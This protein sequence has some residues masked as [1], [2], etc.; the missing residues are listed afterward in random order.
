MLYVADVEQSLK[1]EVDGLR[2]L[3]AERNA[4]YMAEVR[5]KR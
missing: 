4:E 3:R 5:A 1:L 2:A